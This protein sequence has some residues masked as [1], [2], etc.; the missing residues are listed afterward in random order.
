MIEFSKSDIRYL[1]WL[2]AHPHRERPEAHLVKQGLVVNKGG[3]WSITKEGEALVARFD[4][5]EQLEREFIIGK[6]N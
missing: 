5:A 3:L 1:K 6:A 4:S 2:K